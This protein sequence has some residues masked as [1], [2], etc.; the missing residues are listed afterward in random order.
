MD[1]TKTSSSL[2]RKG[3]QALL[4]SSLGMLLKISMMV[5]IR[6]CFFFVRRYVNTSPRYATLKIVKRINI[7]R[8]RRPD[9]RPSRKVSVEDVENCFNEGLFYP[10]K[11]KFSLKWVNISLCSVMQFS[12]HLL[13]KFFLLSSLI[14]RGLF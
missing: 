10:K 11:L 14:W 2:D 8:A 7:K 5:V 3:L 4:R 12:Y 9:L 13:F 6:N 1:F